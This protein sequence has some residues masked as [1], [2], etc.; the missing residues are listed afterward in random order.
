MLKQSFI[1]SILLVFIF[2]SGERKGFAESLLPDS[3]LTETETLILNGQ[4]RRTKLF[5]TLYEAGLYL[6]GKS[7]D[8]ESIVAA[9]KPMA[10]RLIIK[11]SFITSEKMESATLEGFEKSTNGNTSPLDKEINAFIAVFREEIK[12]NDIY[13]IFYLPD[14]GVKVLKNNKPAALIT[15]LAFK[16]ALF[17]IWLSPNPVQQSLKRE[18]L[19]EK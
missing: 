3:L 12:E 15:G 8:A 14:T 4:G 19:G 18:L 10:I 1:L 11:S 2:I 6:Q 7:R 17:G 5:L 16:K 9:D 13:E